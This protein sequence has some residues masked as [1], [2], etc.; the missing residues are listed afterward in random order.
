M[1]IKELPSDLIAEQNLIALALTCARIPDGARDVSTTDF[2][3]GINKGLWAA[4]LELDEEGREIEA[5]SAYDI[6]RRDNEFHSRSFKVSDLSRMTDGMIKVNE[7]VFVEKI[8]NTAARRYAMRELYAA[9]EKVQS[10]EVSLETLKTKIETIDSTN[11]PTGNFKRLGDILETQVKPAL[12]DLRCGITHRISTGFEK[13]DNVIGG[14]LSASDVVIVAAQTGAGKSAFV[15]QLATNIAKQNIPVAFVSGEMSDKENGMRLLSQAA[16]FFNLNSATHIDEQEL[17]FLNQWLEALK[18]LPIYFDST[19]FDL[20]S[21]ARSLR[22]L[23][24]STGIKVLVIDY[25]QLFKVSKGDQKQRTERIAEVSQEMK[26]IA[27]ELGIAVIEVV[28]FNREGAKSIKA[29]MYDLDGSSQLEKDASLIFIIDRDG[30]SAEVSLRLVK[31][32]NTGKFE[33]PGS[34]TGMTLN[35]QF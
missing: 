15:L 26:R 13:I 8:K 25:L 14:G 2:H 17:K 1:E 3:S 21:L 28:Q 31:G 18:P 12:E 16:K 35:F 6:F 11:Q 24:A 32:R 33:I 30:D 34:F 22:R 10:G 19:T 23:V 7:N 20:Q 29:T 4:F 27:M 9:I 5:F